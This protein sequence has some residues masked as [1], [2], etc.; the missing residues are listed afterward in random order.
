[1]KIKKKVMKIDR[2]WPYRRHEARGS[3]HM[4]KV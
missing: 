4:I 3:R 1:M 2:A